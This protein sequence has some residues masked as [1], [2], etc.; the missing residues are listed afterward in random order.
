MQMESALLVPVPE[1]DP[2]V[3]PWRRVFDPVALLGIRAHITVLYPFLP[4]ERLDDE[5]LGTLDQLLSTFPA[6]SYALDE[7]RRWPDLVYLAPNPETPFRALTRLVAERWPEVPPYE[8]KHQDVVPHLTVAYTRDDAVATEIADDLTPHL[9]VV[10]VA[11]HVQLMVT[12][13]ASWTAHTS[14]PLLG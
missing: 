6:F 9:P 5:T 2:I 14:F 4:P 8:G 10:C 3:E 7:V 1:A 13:G 11:R 12:D